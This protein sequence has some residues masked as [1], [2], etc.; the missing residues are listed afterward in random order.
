LSQPL[1]IIK[2]FCEFIVDEK[3]FVFLTMICKSLAS[4]SDFK[5]L[6]KSYTFSKIIRS[7]DAYN[8]INIVYNL[9]SIRIQLMPK[10]LE[11]II[12]SNDF[13][14]DWPQYYYYGAIYTE[15][16]DAMYHVF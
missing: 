15:E 7:V 13:N 10:N 9:E 5:L 14:Y 3:D 1:E 16:D 8:F 2:Y 11:S 12:L 6:T 4:V